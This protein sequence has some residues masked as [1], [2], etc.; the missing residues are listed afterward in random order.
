PRRSRCSP[1]AA[2]RA[3]SSR[4]SRPGTGCGR[5]LYRQESG[6]RA[7][8]GG[9]V[10]DVLTDP[11]ARSMVERRTSMKAAVLRSAGSPLAL[12]DIPVPRPRAEEVLVKVA[13]R[14]VCHSDPHV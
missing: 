3:A 10:Q 2:G 7:L 1:S 5:V 4:S 8:A 11:R 13:A 14:G 9:M 12:E 6:D